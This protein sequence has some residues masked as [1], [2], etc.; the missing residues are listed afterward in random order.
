MGAKLFGVD[1]DVVKAVGTRRVG[2]QPMPDPN[3]RILSTALREVSGQQSMNLQPDPTLGAPFSSFPNNR[4]TV[5]QMGPGE[6]AE[7]FPLGG[8]PRMWKYRV[9][10]N[11]PTT[12]DTD[13]GIS[14]ELLRVLADSFWLL[15]RCIEI[16][17]AEVC[18]LDWEI[19]PKGRNGKEK[20]INGERNE[21]L[22][23][24]LKDFFLYPEG[25][26]SFITPDDEWTPA[27]E[28]YV[29]DAGAWRRKGLVDWTDWLNAV[30]EDFFVGDWVSL[31]PQRTLGNEMIGVR[32]VDGEHIKALLDLDGR[33]PPPP[34][35]AYQQYLYGVPRASWAAN[36]FY[37]VPRNV[38]NMTPYGFSHVQQALIPINLGL[39]FDQWNTA[40]YT[41]ST[42]PMGLL[43]SAPGFTADQIK[44]VADFLNG[45]VDSLASRQRVYPVPNG[46]K[47]QTLKPFNFDE[48]FAMYLIECICAAMDVQPQELGYAPSRA[49]L[50][51]A[52]F[53]E[54]Q[55][56]IRQRKGLHPLAKWLE[57]KMTKI[58][59]DQWS[60][61]GGGELEFKFSDL[62]VENEA[63]KYAAN[64]AA[65]K[66]GQIS[67]DHL[68]ED[69][70]QTGLGVGYILETEQGTIF[71]DKGYALTGS[72]IVQLPRDTNATISAPGLAPAQGTPDVP[73]EP[74][75]EPNT[76]KYDP[77]TPPV[78]PVP[79]VANTEQ[80]FDQPQSDP[81]DTHL[82]TAALAKA[83]TPTPER[84]KLEE[85]FL[86]AW[87]AWWHKKTTA[88]L[89]D[90]APS[91]PEVAKRLFKVSVDEQNELAKILYNTDRHPAFVA[92]MQKLRK[93]RGL[94]EGAWAEP[95]RSDIFRL[96]T[97]TQAHMVRVIQTYHTDLETAFQ[98]L[99]EEQSG[100]PNRQ[101]AAAAIVMGLLAWLNG[102][103]EW[104][105]REIAI[106]EATDAEAQAMSDFATQNPKLLGALRWRA[107][108]DEKT[109]DVCAGLDGQ[110]LD[111]T[112]P[113]PPAHPNCLPG[114][115]NVSAKGVSAATKRW[116]EG[117]M[118]TIRT[119]S[120]KNL[121]CTP[122][123]PILTSSG[124]VPGG[125]IAEGDYVI[126]SLSS[127]WVPLRNNNHDDVPPMIHEVADAFFRT[128][129]VVSREVPVSA[130]DFHGDGEGSEVAV[131][132]ANGLLGNGVDTTSQKV[133]C[134]Y[135][136]HRRGMETEGKNSTGSPDP[137]V[138]TRPSATNGVV[139]IGA[140]LTSLFGSHTTE[141]NDI[142][143]GPTTDTNTSSHQNTTNG[144]ATYPE[145][146]GKSELGFTATIT[147]NDLRRR[148]SESSVRK[149]TIAPSAPLNGDAVFDQD[150]PDWGRA[151]T[152]LARQILQGALGPVLP[153]EVIG[154]D[155]DEAWVGQVFNLQTAT[156][157][158]TANAIVTH[159]CRCITEPV[160]DEALSSDSTSGPQDPQ[161]EGEEAGR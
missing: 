159:N 68:L 115:T 42:V 75:P 2:A 117:K 71:L 82:P 92:A 126:R 99:F 56:Q 33:I 96:Q 150:S 20:K 49:S 45:A 43:E 122:N 148:Q 134:D 51:G 127:E 8:E 111:S 137:L 61:L 87:L 149:T 113:R 18:A 15:R 143:L 80:H 62:V 136:L 107:V 128:S 24:H 48:K 74:A 106:T 11:F 9:G 145:G 77:T 65:L 161:D 118:V 121:S 70:G 97:Q 17:K 158:Y 4:L 125:K 129:Q 46:T 119:A 69:S 60:N 104:K 21:G 105:G 22:I 34:M 93:E 112:G 14:G 66:S 27:G 59:N 141:P 19:V 139:S 64:A 154:V 23:R 12:P 35:P 103:L 94:P 38:R 157:H 1:V 36:E 10:W 79:P 100:N 41:E 135:T 31:W 50:G 98:S 144:T 3:A 85:E 146:G 67:L 53:A 138:H 120:G 91:D 110:I 57:R 95:T 123:H 116:Y 88:L 151:D 54:E 90:G 72:G 52:G 160:G 83:A 6:P 155:V 153:D 29:Q 84:E 131:I 86:A 124:W 26:Y 142:G 152:E 81:M 40:A 156:G 89:K 25:Y 28:V 37:Y 55:S 102:R 101:T 132:G 32:R 30:L 73:L 47:W 16:R 114:T 58:I 108:M 63:E 130:E 109:C 5:A 13:R 147:I 39:R 140:Q 78:D 7:N 133:I 44:D 76:P